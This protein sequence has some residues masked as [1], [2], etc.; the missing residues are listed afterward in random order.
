MRHT[1]LM[2]LGLALLAVAGSR[3][4]AAQRSGGRAAD[5]RPDSP[6]ATDVLEDL[7]L[8]TILN[9]LSVSQ[10]QAGDLAGP[11]D[12]ARAK[13]DAVEAQ[14]R[15]QGDRLRDQIIFDEAPATLRRPGE[16]A[17]YKVKPTIPDAEFAQYLHTC[18]E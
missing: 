1:W 18:R 6:S 9:S 3:P 10:K 17:R 15:A 4:A 12:S 16:T 13:M 7:R 8:L 11:A 5:A 14:E 2:L